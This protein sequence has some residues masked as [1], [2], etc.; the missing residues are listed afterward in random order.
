MVGRARAA[1]RTANLSALAVLRLGGLFRWRRSTGPGLVLP[2]L[3][4]SRPSGGGG[5]LGERR[6]CTRGSDNRATFRV[7]RPSRSG[8]E[9]QGCPAECDGLYYFT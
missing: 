6:A 1:V 2:S 7:G 5:C 9:G 3:L 4:P 8:T